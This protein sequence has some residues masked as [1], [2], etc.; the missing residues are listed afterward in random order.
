[1]ACVN[2]GFA[3]VILG[4]SVTF[5]FLAN[6][7]IVS[8]APFF[9]WLNPRV[10]TYFLAI[11]VNSWYLGCSFHDFFL[12]LPKYH[13]LGS[14]PP[15][16]GVKSRLGALRLYNPWGKGVPLPLFVHID[17]GKNVPIT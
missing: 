14:L 2:F 16:L 10:P 12:S 7:C 5:N 9:G 15:G 1:M 4:G 17:D 3:G 11:S 6:E 8:D 13:S